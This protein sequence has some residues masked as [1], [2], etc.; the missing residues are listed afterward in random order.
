MCHGACCI[1]INNCQRIFIT[2]FPFF[3]FVFFFIPE[4]I[5][6]NRNYCWEV[7]R[8]YACR[9]GHV[10]TNISFARLLF[11][12]SAYTRQTRAWKFVNGKLHHWF[13]FLSPVYTAARRGYWWTLQ[14]PVFPEPCKPLVVPLEASRKLVIL[15]SESHA[16]F[17][18]DSVACVFSVSE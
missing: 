4:I 10:Q 17:T 15:A 3:R 16:L 8:R 12:N 6:R 14:L 11:D 5:F 2:H 9:G 13:T 7:G 1:D 18:R